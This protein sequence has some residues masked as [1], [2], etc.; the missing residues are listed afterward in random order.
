MQH[1]GCICFPVTQLY[2]LPNIPKKIL[3]NFGLILAQEAPEGIEYRKGTDLLAQRVTVRRPQ[4][5]LLGCQRVNELEGRIA[6]VVVVADENGIANRREL[7]AEVVARGIVEFGTARRPEQRRLEDAVAEA[8]KHAGV[9]HGPNEGVVVET[10]LGRCAV[11]AG[12]P[13]GFPGYLHSRGHHGVHGDLRDIG[14]R[15]FEEDGSVSQDKWS[16]IRTRKKEIVALDFG[17]RLPREEGIG[18]CPA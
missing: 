18:E 1:I 14:G 2:C 16:A 11:Q 8:R 9:Q 7:T 12:G 17:T 5:D 15:R 10:R 4:R 6:N 3:W 13:A